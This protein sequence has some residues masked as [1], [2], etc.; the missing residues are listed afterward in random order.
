MTAFWRRRADVKR[1]KTKLTAPGIDNASIFLVRLEPRPHERITHSTTA[2]EP[3][4]THGTSRRRGVDILHKYLAGSI[5]SLL[6]SH[7][8]GCYGY[9]FG[10]CGEAHPRLRAVV[11]ACESAISAW[12]G[13]WRVSRR[14]CVRFGLGDAATSCKR[15]HGHELGAGPKRRVSTFLS[16]V[17]VWAEAHDTQTRTVGTA[18]PMLACTA[19]CAIMKTLKRTPS[20]LGGACFRSAR[21]KAN[22]GSSQ[23]DHGL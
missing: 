2:L 18:A 15:V 4:T 10:M 3:R 5:E 12:R 23:A 19:W 13:A 7:E 22:A 1:R 14:S 11:L 8:G 20:R 17:C 9:G 6:L 16:R 21:G